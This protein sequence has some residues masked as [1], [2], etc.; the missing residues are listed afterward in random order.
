MEPISGPVSDPRSERRYETLM[1]LA[2]GGMATVYIGYLRGSLGFRQIV[3]IKRPHPHLLYDPNFKRSFID[4]AKIACRIHHANVV[5]V[6]DV[7]VTADSIDLVMDYVEGAS[8]SRLVEAAQQNL[9]P[10]PPTVAIRIAL[11][12][13]AGLHA[14]HEVTDEQGRAL[15]LVHRDVSPQ[16][17]LVGLDG[18]SRVTDFGIAKSRMGGGVTT[19]EGVFKGKLSY[20]APEYLLSKGFD[21]RADVFAMGVVLW[22]SLMGQRLFH[23]ENEPDTIMRVLKA[24]APALSALPPHIAAAFD[25]VVARAL[26]KDPHDRYPTMVDLATAIE[27]AAHACQLRPNHREVAAFVSSIVGPDVET[28][29]ARIRER[30]ASPTAAQLNPADSLVAS[31]RGPLSFVPPPALTARPAEIEAVTGMQVSSMTAMHAAPVRKRWW[32]VPL[33]ILTVGI[34]VAV[35]VLIMNSLTSPTTG[36]PTAAP[37]VASAQAAPSQSAS[38]PVAVLPAE[39]VAPSGAASTAR[40][41]I[42]KTQAPP[43]TQKTAT[44]STIKGP[45]PNPYAK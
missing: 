14:A 44:A 39:L 38:S 29:R 13:C 42:A 30:M 22:E 41:P 25:P 35:G 37:L 15:G 21:R 16:N 9:Q 23:G 11:D 19:Q 36:A 28:R 7:D 1:E 10:M 33:A 26:V 27:D 2:A 34:G 32:L 43:K 12:A 4:E 24:N 18:V 45:P 5:D 20:M 40:P 8:L 17:I 31:S 3:A 6:R